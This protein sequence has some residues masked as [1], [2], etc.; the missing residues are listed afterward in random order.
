MPLVISIAGSDPGRGAGLQMDARVCWRMGV[1]FRGVV[2]VDTVQDDGG[3][4]S[5]ATRPP[6]QVAEELRAALAVVDELDG[7]SNARKPGLAI[8]TGALGNDGIVEALADVLREFNQQNGLDR[9]VPLVIDPVRAA[10][11]NLGAPL[12]NEAG[13]HSM[14]QLL[15]PLAS[16][17]T[18]NALEYGDGSEFQSCRGVLLKGGHRRL[19]FAERN[20]ESARGD[21]P[22]DGEGQQIRD[23]FWREGKLI[24]TVTKFHIPGATS[25]HGT[26]CALSTAI[27]VGLAQQKETADAI[28]VGS[29]ALHQWLTA[30]IQQ[31][32]ALLAD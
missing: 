2:A 17:V 7:S 4:Q 15:F 5:V 27:A 9:G 8:K 21:V 12:L 26:G 3:L 30:A 32:T 14:K 6:E 24:H 22:L 28:E 16:L 1:Q 25:L 20:P 23:E 18:P 29:F 11:K 31:T 10:T 19:G 13:W